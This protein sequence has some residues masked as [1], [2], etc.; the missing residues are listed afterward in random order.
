MYGAG[1]GRLYAIKHLSEQED[2]ITPAK[3]LSMSVKYKV[4]RWFKTSYQTLASIPLHAADPF[5]LG[6]VP[7]QLLHRLLTTRH[8]VDAIRWELAVRSPDMYHS[9]LTAFN[10]QREGGCA[11][12]MV[13]LWDQTARPLLA[14]SWYSHETVLKMLLS[15]L[16]EADVCSCCR[17]IYKLNFEHLFLKEPTT[18]AQDA[19]DAFNEQGFTEDD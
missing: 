4:P 9:R 19:Q 2:E 13:G 7:P 3:L 17:D 16:A 18:I 8:V 6:A 1:A 11:D 12:I 10:C 15:K 14:R 5:D